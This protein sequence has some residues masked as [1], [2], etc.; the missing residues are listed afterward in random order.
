MPGGGCGLPGRRG[1]VSGDR[2]GLRGCGGAKP[3]DDSLPLLRD[4]RDLRLEIFPP[5]FLSA[6]CVISECSAY[7]FSPRRQIPRLFPSKN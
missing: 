2:S 5:A 3:G 7:L 4:L 6:L 1:A